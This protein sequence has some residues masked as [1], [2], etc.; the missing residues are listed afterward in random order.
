MNRLKNLSQI[1]AV[2]LISLLA[3]AIVATGIALAY[4]TMIP[5]DA[6]SALP[7][8]TIVVRAGDSLQRA[9]NNAS[10]G[11]TLVLDAGAV[12]PGTITLT[13]KPGA[14]TAYIT[15]QSSRAAELPVNKQVTPAD[16]PKMA[17]I[18]SP[19]NSAAAIETQL[20]AHH[21]KL[22]G[23]EVRP[24]NNTAFAYD[25][26]RFG[27][28]EA[29]QNTVASQAHH[30]VIDRSYVHIF[31]DQQIK[32][33]LALN[34]SDTD[35]TNSW[36][37]QFKVVGQDSQAIAGWNSTGNLRIINNHLEAASYPFILG[38]DY[39]QIP[40]LVATNVQFVHNYCTRPLAWRGQGYGIKN[41][42]ELKN[43]KNVLIDG[44]VFENNWTD[45]QNGTAIL[46]TVSGERGAMPQATIEDITFSNNRVINSEMGINILGKDYMGASQIAKR[47]TI[48]NNSFEKLQG[49][50]LT[51][52]DGQDITL[53]HNTIDSTGYIVWFYGEPTLR[54]V[55]TNN[56]ANR[57]DYGFAGDGIGIG[58][59]AINFYA[60]QAVV[61]GNV[62]IGAAE[63]MPQQN[64]YVDN[65]AQV[66]FVDYATR[67]LRL[68]SKSPYSK[69]GTNR[70]DVGADFAALDAAIGG[71][72]LVTPTIPTLTRH[73]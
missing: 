25:L 59:V 73:K 15:I 13:N 54:F 47:I 9:I 24:V 66:G 72:P 1:K 71:T 31:P 11:D 45:G 65:A 56:I 50:F 52:T 32:R 69:K 7:A 23:I 19:G 58:S 40:G 20:A 26:I 55:F 33:G 38:G 34:S 36:F 44:N 16:L 22:I 8:G 57:N 35:V 5:A 17:T 39:A 63:R 28:A 2:L 51:I 18:T 62:I 10:P 3:V 53:D 29:T 48:K 4:N 70:K 27:T 46:F 49:R 67:N 68:L 64:Y 60:P 21:Y 42:F 12:F 30:L 37:D 14:S 61:T 6:I 41:L 43:A